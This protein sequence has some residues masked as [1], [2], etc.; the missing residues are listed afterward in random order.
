MFEQQ[1]NLGI[2]E[3]MWND[4]NKGMTWELDM[5][6]GGLS[7]RLEHEHL[8]HICSLNVFII[9]LTMH[10]AIFVVHPSCPVHPPLVVVAIFFPAGSY[11]HLVILV[12][13][14]CNQKQFHSNAPNIALLSI[15]MVHPHC[16]PLSMASH[17]PT[18]FAIPFPP[19]PHCPALS[20]NHPYHYQP[21]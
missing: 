15:D 16:G 14:T 2:L 10:F 6:M 9:H 11:I 13:P 7:K 4:K 1:V 12:C 20:P 3:K 17:C 21:Y 5:V 8:L 19:I 18:L